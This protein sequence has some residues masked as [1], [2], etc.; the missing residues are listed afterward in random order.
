MSAAANLSNAVERFRDAYHARPDLLEEL[1]DWTRA[2]VLQASDT[3]EAVT[4]R[5]HGGRVE[6]WSEGEAA[7]AEVVITS[8]ATTLRD[9]LELRRRPD[10]PYLFGELTV[11]GAQ[12]D[13]LRLDYLIASLGAP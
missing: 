8:D 13:F 7:A 11:R 9:V 6:G 3:G 4:V 1:K 12:E 10:D 2:I 5:I